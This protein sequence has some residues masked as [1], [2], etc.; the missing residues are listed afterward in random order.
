MKYFL[1]AILII[2]LAACTEEKGPSP[3][4]GY[5]FFPL[6][7]GKYWIY[8]VDSIVYDDEGL[9]VDT[10]H[11][12]FREE[13]KDW[14]LNSSGDTTFICERFESYDSINW[15][16]KEVFSLERTRTQALRT[17]NNLRFIKMIFPIHRNERWDGHRFFDPTFNVPIAGENMQVFLD[18]EYRYTDVQNDIIT[19]SQADY[20][21]NINLRKAE[22]QYARG[23]GLVQRNW[24]I[25]YT[26]CNTCCNGNSALVCSDS[27]WSFKAERGFILN[28]YLVAH[29]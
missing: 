18:W 20:D 13:I 25:L 21:N 15:N 8:Q 11:L 24:S 26:Q 1:F 29:N 16:I 2:G 12:F 27:T 19:I 14:R 28:Q 6:Q 9:K 3:D 5:D 17:E 22:E 10:T 23:I 4:L 7:V